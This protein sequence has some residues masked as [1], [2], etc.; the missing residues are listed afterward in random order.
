MKF[1]LHRFCYVKI[2]KQAVGIWRGLIHDQ[3][4]NFLCENRASKSIFTQADFDQACARARSYARDHLAFFLP[5]FEAEVFELLGALSFVQLIAFDTKKNPYAHLFD[6]KLKESLIQLTISEY[7]R[8][9]EIQQTP[10]L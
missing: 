3:S 9:H 5:N 7:C 10:P 6:K 4:G 2:L 1:Q 8:K